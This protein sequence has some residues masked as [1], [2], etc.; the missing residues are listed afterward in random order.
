MEHILNIHN[1]SKDYGHIRALN[2]LSLD[3]PKGSVFGLLGPNGSGKTTTLAI[4]LGILKQSEGDFSWFGG[5]FDF[6]AKQRV[7]AILETPN[8][9]PYLSAYKNL[10]VVAQVKE[11]T[12]PK[13]DEVLELVKLRDRAKS[14]FKTYSLGMKQRLA[15]ASALL[16]EPEVLILDEPT[17]GLD[18][19]G[20]AEIRQMIKDIAARGITVLIASHLL[21]E[22]E[23]VCTHVAVIKKGNLLYSG[24]V[25][26]LTKDSGFIELSSDDRN[27]LKKVLQTLPEVSKVEEIGNLLRVSGSAMLNATSLNRQLA[28]KGVYLNHLEQKKTSLEDHFLE[29]TKAS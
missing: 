6:K 24:P 28:Q 19:E 15:I 11:L 4:L 17:N 21:V 7:G 14:K 29:L 26:G 10:E 2:R 23:K 9:Y 22:V 20:I 1:L 18:P 8:F 25:E 5:A 12:K 13:Y 3:I 16:C 27:G